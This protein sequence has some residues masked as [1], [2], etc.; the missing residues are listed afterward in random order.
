ML[1]KIRSPSDLAKAVKKRSLAV[2]IDI[3]ERLWHVT[4]PH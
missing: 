3:S 1:R 2:A 4:C